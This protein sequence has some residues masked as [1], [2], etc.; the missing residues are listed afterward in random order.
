MVNHK[1]IYRIMKG[2]GLK[3]VCRK[4]GKNILNLPHRSQR[5]IY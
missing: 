3:S 5:K 2:L 1:R 4:K